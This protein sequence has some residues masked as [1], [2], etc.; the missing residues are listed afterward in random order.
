MALT[1]G[2]ASSSG[3][4]AV[5][6]TAVQSGSWGELPYSLEVLTASTEALAIF[7]ALIK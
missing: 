7:T 2:F 1:A 5:A 6:Q 4:A 3:E